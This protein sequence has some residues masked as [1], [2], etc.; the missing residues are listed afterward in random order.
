RTMSLYDFS[1]PQFIKT[2]GNLDKWFDK[3]E[4]HAAA[5]KFDPAVYLTL[6]LAP[7][8]LPFVKQVHIATDSAKLGVSRVTGKAAPTFEDNET[9]LAQLRERIQKTIAFLQSVTPVDFEGAATRVVERPDGTKILGQDQLIQ[10]TIPTF[11][12]HAVTTYAIL[13]HNGVDLGKKD[14]LGALKLIG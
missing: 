5:K 8:Q 7:D 9:T 1:V 4:A 6:R 14:Y 13:R 11:F 10:H 3:A 12:F 2:L